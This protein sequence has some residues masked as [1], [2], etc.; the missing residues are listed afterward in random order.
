MDDQA[1]AVRALA[2]RAY[3][4]KANVGIYGHSYGG[5]MAASCAL[6]HPDL[7]RAAVAGAPVTDWRNYD[8]IYTERWMRTPVE[9]PQ[10]YAAACLPCRAA[11]LRTG[12]LLLHGMV[13]DNVHPA[14]T[15][16]LAKALQDQDIP[17]EML[18]FPTSDHGIHS[19]MYRS[20][21]W[22]FLLERLGPVQPARL[23][24]APQPEPAEASR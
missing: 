16:Q 13:D 8:T 1:A 5:T 24:P 2:D 21:K 6:R 17:F 18:I 15:L 19:P 23:P 10:G 22:S 20:A 14:N 3:V 11:E 12:L 4:D 7:F 9:N